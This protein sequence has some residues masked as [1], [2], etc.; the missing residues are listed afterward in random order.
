MSGGPSHGETQNS[1][2]TDGRM[3]AD[4]PGVDLYELLGGEREASKAPVHG[5]VNDE[6]EK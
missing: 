2:Y 3:K 4:G 1:P 5:E 6:L